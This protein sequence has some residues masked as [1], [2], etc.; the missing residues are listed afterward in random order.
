MMSLTL[1]I[2]AAACALI[3]LVSMDIVKDIAVEQGDKK[4]VLAK[5]ALRFAWLAHVAALGLAY[6]AGAL[7]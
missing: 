3:G 4:S 7:A 6:A 2:A 5:D 1:I